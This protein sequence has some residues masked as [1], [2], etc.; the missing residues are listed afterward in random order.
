[1]VLGVMMLKAG[2]FHYRQ[3]GFVRARNLQTPDLTLCAT[4]PFRQKNQNYTQTSSL[5]DL[6][7]NSFHSTLPYHSRETEAAD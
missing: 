4:S 7:R 5:G 6:I 3:T 1:M 2:E